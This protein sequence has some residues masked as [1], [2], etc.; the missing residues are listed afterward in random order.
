MDITQIKPKKIYRF[1]QPNGISKLVT[2]ISIAPKEILVK[3]TDEGS[4]ENGAKRTFNVIE[5]DRY[6]REIEGYDYTDEKHLELAGQV[7]RIVDAI[8][9]DNTDK[10]RGWAKMELMK[11]LIF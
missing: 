9:Q 8:G 6:I 2:V 11:L 10:T 5:C 7:N 3:V 1:I 4:S